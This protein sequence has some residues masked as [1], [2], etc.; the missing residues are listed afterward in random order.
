M[1]LFSGKCQIFGDLK[2]H[3]GDLSDDSIRL[4]LVQ[5][6]REVSERRD[7]LDQKDNL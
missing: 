6:F 4:N 7:Q 2:N 5:F 3:F 1:P